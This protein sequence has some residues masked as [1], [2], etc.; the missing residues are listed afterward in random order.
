[1]N[2]HLTKHEEDLEVTPSY[3]DVDKELS[4]QEA[5]EKMRSNSSERR[6]RWE[7]EER[8][9]QNGRGI[10]ILSRT[11]ATQQYFRDNL[12]SGLGKCGL[13]T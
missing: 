12:T 2:L 13:T 10:G 4:S 6:P 9:A 5:V 1:M 8:E 3:K 7:D 11:T